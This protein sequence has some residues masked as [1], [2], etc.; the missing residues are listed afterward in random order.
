MRDI[1]LWINIE[2]KLMKQCATSKSR[3]MS[4]TGV[5]KESIPFHMGFSKAR[6][7]ETMDCPLLFSEVFLKLLHLVFTIPD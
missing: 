7:M 4:R 1:C 3:K 2:K 5:R 6:G